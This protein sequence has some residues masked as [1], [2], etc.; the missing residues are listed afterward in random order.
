LQPID[1]L[2]DISARYQAIFCD[3]W[4]V[5]HNGVTPFED[6]VAALIKA[7]K[8][9]LKV[10]LVTNA[11]RPFQSVVDQLNE[12][13]V[14]PLA[15]DGIVTSGDVTRALIEKAN[16]KIL[17]IGSEKEAVLFGGLKV[18]LVAEADAATVIVTGLNN[19]DVETPDD[20]APLLARLKARNIPMICANPDITVHRGDRLTWC[21]GALAMEYAKLGGQTS[22]AGKPHHLIYDAAHKMANKLTGKALLKSDIVAIG[23]GLFT[24]IKGAND[25]G[26]DALYVAAGVHVHEYAANNVIDEGKMQAFVAGHGFSPIASVSRLK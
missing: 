19:D 23:D 14:D 5:V 13:G 18:Q 7:R 21:G 16:P 1:S 9:G 25:Y 2:S 11:P 4:G 26:V 15:Y 22:I 8:A 12:I 17:H 3:V 20:Y 6:G 10:V 24:D